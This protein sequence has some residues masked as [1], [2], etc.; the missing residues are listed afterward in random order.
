M[1]GSLFE[2][3]YQS[4]LSSLRDVGRAFAQKHPAIAGLLA[5][6]GGDP[7]VEQLLEGFSFVAARLRQRIDGATPQLV[8]GMTELLLPH[9][10]RPTPASTIVE[11]HVAPG[12]S[13]GAQRLALG[14]TLESRS[15][16]GVVCPFRTSRALAL[17][18]L[19]LVGQ[20]LDDSSALRPELCLRF[21]TEQGAAF[22]VFGSEGL[23]LHLHGELPTTTQLYLWFARYVGGVTLRTEDGRSVELGSQAVK[24]VGLD[25]TD[26][27][28][29]WPAFSPHGARLLLEYFALMPKFLFIDVTGLERAAH[30]VSTSFELVFRFERP[31]ALSA[32]LSDDALRLHCVPAIN[33]FEVAGEPVRATIEGRATLLRAA[34]IEPL[35]AEVFA[36]RSVVGMSAD[37]SE[38]HSYEPFH[39]FRHAL[40]AAPHHGFYQLKRERSPVDD[41]MHTFLRLERSLEV[42]TFDEET[43]SIELTCTSRSAANELQ[44]G[45]V[46]VPTA[47]T[48]AGVSFSNISLVCRATRPPLGSDLSWYLIAHLSA[49]RRS[50]A[51]VEVLKSLLSLYNFQEGSD[52]RKGRANRARIEAIRT[53]SSK[54]ITRVVHGAAVRG[55]LFR[56]EVEQAGFTSEGDAFLFGSVLHRLLA[57]QSEINTFA[58]LELML[59]PTQLRFRWKMELPG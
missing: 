45:D 56:V 53:V 10:L 52:H 2:H 15:A 7:E 49:S 31:P 33:L 11:F 54:I 39:T 17:S 27:L 8:E 57:S 26:T 25:D 34:G 41:G 5:E 48:P 4:E 24:P 37:R 3:Y 23:R 6:R 43:L 32:R 29:P 42:L 47:D 9:L 58:D 12:S 20:R 55:T 13:H 44:V 22:S 36:V 30:L 59:R 28:F 50:L 14:T 38:R 16:R 51:D 19:R 18:P 46:R 1:S 21:E 40:K 35:Q